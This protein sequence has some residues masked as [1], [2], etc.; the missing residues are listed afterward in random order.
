M[1]IDYDNKVECKN[2]LIAALGE[3]KEIKDMSLFRSQV[4]AA[5]NETGA[6]SKKLEGNIKVDT[7][8]K[9]LEFFE[10]RKEIGT[11]REIYDVIP[12]E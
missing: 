6:Y 8:N 10:I 12:R 5:C 3:D 11:K 4:V 9:V 1:R 7:I 2:R